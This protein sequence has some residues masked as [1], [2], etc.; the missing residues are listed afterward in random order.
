[1]IMKSLVKVLSLVTVGSLPLF[2]QAVNPCNQNTQ[3]T[4][5]T[6]V[7]VTGSSTPQRIGTISGTNYSYEVWHAKDECTGTNNMTYYGASQGGGAA[8]KANWTQGSRC[9]FL[10]RVGYKWDVSGKS[11]NDYEDIFADYNYT[12]TAHVQGSSSVAGDYSYIGIY[13]WVRKTSTTST[14][15][16]YIVDDWF[17]N[18]WQLDTQ[19]VGADQIGAGSYLSGK[20]YTMDGGTYK[21]YK[22]TRTNAYSI[23]SDN[24]T[25]DQYF[26]VRQTIRQCGTISVTEHFKKW[27]EAGLPMAGTLYEAK[28]LAEAGGGA[29]SIDYRYANLRL[30][31]G[32]GGSSSS[33]GGSSSS[34]E[35]VSKNC[36]TLPASPVPTEPYNTCFKYPGSNEKYIGKCY[37]CHTRNEV[38]GNTCSSEWVW[39]GSQPYLDDNLDEGYWYDETPCEE[40]VRIIVNKA[41]LTQFS[42]RP[43]GKALLVE[44]SVPATIVVYNLKGK[45]QASFN[46]SGSQTVNISL[47]SGMYFAKVHGVKT[48]HVR[49]IVK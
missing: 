35:T 15:E 38:D 2:A 28:L 32:G 49:F 34:T 23:D 3:L 22:H 26:S 18:Q 11:Y 37:V 6:T 7:S 42:I 30:S 10:A 41:P 8:F 17:G 29:G 31:S 14:V 48:Q 25:F 43:S 36:I 9:D 33:D 4:G 16:Y 13:G 40:P 5:G 24:D 19:P 47:P 21:I 12:R 20:D 45:K 44:A 27:E 1:M 46:V 39:S